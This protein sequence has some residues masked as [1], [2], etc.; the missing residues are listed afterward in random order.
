M[1]RGNC[2]CPFVTSFLLLLW[3]IYLTVN[4]DE[5]VASSFHTLRVIDAPSGVEPPVQDILALFRVELKTLQDHFESQIED[6][7]E[8]IIM[9]TKDVENQKVIISNLERIER[10]LGYGNNGNGN[11]DG[12]DNSNRCGFRYDSTSDKCVFN[13][14]T[15]F[16]AAG[17]F[18]SN[19]SVGGTLTASSATLS[20][21]FQA[22]SAKITGNTEIAGT[23]KAGD[24]TV[25]GAMK[26]T[27]GS[28]IT[29]IRSGGTTAL[30]GDLEVVNGDATLGTVTADKITVDGVLG[31]HDTTVSGVLTITKANSNK[32][33]KI[34]SSG[35]S[36]FGG[37]VIVDGTVTSTGE[38]FA[39]AFNS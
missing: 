9:L 35:T 7:N 6:L 39:P 24:T 33:T 17:S 15:S 3:G 25:N 13:K 10:R 28:A 19:V 30:A 12:S 26:V 4:G 22:G 37:N 31:A 38:M 20:G 36:R 8:Q 2:K 1:A 23:V 11:G 16:T 21:A 18:T 29:W 34:K 32:V 14:A 5:E 27:D